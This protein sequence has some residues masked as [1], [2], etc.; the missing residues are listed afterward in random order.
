MAQPL[1][2][3]SCRVHAARL[4]HR[5]LPS[6]DGCKPLRGDVTGLLCCLRDLRVGRVVITDAFQPSASVRRTSLEC[7]EGTE[8][9]L[10]EPRDLPHDSSD[11]WRVPFGLALLSELQQTLQD[12]SFSLDLSS[13]S[14]RNRKRPLH[15]LARNSSGRCRD[16]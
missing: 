8:Q 2:G 4:P 9:P 5:T 16:E 3:P 14:C 11:S 7:P 13:S 12:R 6:S 15:H 1:S 10:F